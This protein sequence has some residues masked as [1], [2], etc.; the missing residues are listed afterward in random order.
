MINL[1]EKTWLKILMVYSLLFLVVIPSYAATPTTYDWTGTNG[2]KWDDKTNWSVGGATASAYPGQL[3]ST[4]D[5]QIGVSNTFT[6]MPV[7]YSTL[8]MSIHSLTFGSNSGPLSLTINSGFSLTVSGALTVNSNSQVTSLVNNGTVT[9]GSYSS[10]SGATFNVSGSNSFSVTGPVTNAGTLIQSG[11]GT[12]TTGAVTNSGTINETGTGSLVFSSTFDN[13]GTAN[14]GPGTVSITG[15]FSNDGTTNFGTG[16]ATLSGPFTVN[17]GSINFGTGMV[18]FSAPA[19]GQ[20][21]IMMT[22][23]TT[24]VFKNVTFENKTNYLFQTTGG[25]ASSGFAVASTGTLTLAN[26]AML[27]F[28]NTYGLTLYSDANGSAAV[29]PIP[30]GCSIGQVYVQ[31]YIT[32]NNSNTYRG[33]RLLSSP[34]YVASVGSVNYISLAYLNAT[35]ANGVHGA[36]TGGPTGPPSF[37]ITNGN[38]SIYLYNESLPISNAYFVSG[39]HVGIYAIDQTSNTPTSNTVTTYS[40][41]TGPVVIKTG[42][43][44]PVG[45]GYLLYFL[46]SNNTRTTGTTLIAPDNTTLTATGFLNQGDITVNLWYAPTGGTS[47]QLSYTASLPG[48]GFNMVGNPYACTIDLSKVI[49]D[50]TVGINGITNI[51]TLDPTGPTQAYAAYTAAGSSAPKL[52]YAVSGEGFLVQASGTGKTLTFHESEKVATQALTGVLMGKPTNEPTLTG[53][54][55][56]LEQDSIHHSYCGI[57]FRGDWS[58]NFKPGDAIDI[59]DYSALDI[60]SLSADGFHAAVNHRSDYTKGS[61]IRLYVNASAGGAY[62]LKIEGIRNIDT[63]HD[64]WLVDHYKNDSLN[65]RRQGSYAFNIVK[66]DTASYGNN[67]FVLAIRSNPAYAYQLLDFA[68]HRIAHS[69]HVELDWKTRYEQNYINFTVERSN[70]GGKSFTVAGGLAGTGAGNYSLTDKNA[71]DGQN[72]YRLKQQDI[73]GTITYSQVVEVTMSGNGNSD[74]VHVYPNP[75][76]NVI[77]LNVTG[78]TTGNT[79]YD[80][81]V[82]NSS[83]LIV[84]QAIS[85]QL[86]WQANVA[87]LLPGTYLVKVL[88]KKDKSLL[89][90]TKFVKL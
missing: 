85:A 2:S 25:G 78:K 82:T 42:V 49:S 28:A 21:K 54:Y 75:A 46:G 53:L 59:N 9:V 26:K 58:D 72:F 12:L 55:M 83:G 23:N 41:A 81:L 3:V 22:P 68:A 17:A 63:L 8:P 61:R 37:T 34:V 33:Y 27:T 66:S 51:Y 32:G 64:I 88:D 7:L 65:I 74:L 67:R 36:F 29:A 71:L 40:N 47:G 4:D 56:K 89:G 80:I 79:S 60:S 87:D 20:N 31:R 39:K 45:N 35:T 11:S 30:P 50:N 14:F 15:A 73:A 69:S 10:V 44:I 52:G 6:K 13:S 86:N 43:S 62:T 19:G 24:L 18:T 76:I 1:M 16:Q 90:Q 38:P 48:P 5:V 70:D 57:Y 84:K 77:N